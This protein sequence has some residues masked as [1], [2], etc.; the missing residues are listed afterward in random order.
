MLKTYIKHLVIIAITISFSQLSLAQNTTSTNSPEVIRDLNQYLKAVNLD[1]GVISNKENLNN[2]LSSASND[3]WNNEIQFWVSAQ[4][5]TNEYK[6]F[7]SKQFE[8]KGN[9]LTSTGNG[10]R[11]AKISEGKYYGI[12]FDGDNDY[13]VNSAFKSVQPY[14]IFIV[15]KTDDTK[16]EN[17]LL[18]SAGTKVNQIRVEN[19]KD[20]KPELVIE[21]SGTFKIPGLTND[22][23]YILIEY[24][25][26]DSKVFVNEKLVYDGFIGRVD[27]DGIQIGKGTVNN[28]Y[29]HLKG[30]IYEIGII[31]NTLNEQARN[32][33]FNLMKKT[34]DLK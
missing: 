7:I 13:W 2:F 5:G 9:N 20:G 27:F 21:S 8:L 24:N 22:I 1:K 33:L 17:V 16:A 31:Q 14:S 19:G 6:G 28:K 30:L 12:N 29:N 10:N 32:N 11:P 3:K 18:E 25:M 23:N 4:W 26:K 34:Y 15:F